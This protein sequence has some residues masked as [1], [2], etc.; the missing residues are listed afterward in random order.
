MNY[1]K[2]HPFTILEYLYKFSFLFIIP[3]LQ[4]LIIRPRKIIE[5]INIFGLNILFVLLIVAY[6]IKEYTAINYH[7]SKHSFYISQGIIVKKR[8]FI[9]YKN[10]HSII[11]SQNLI[12][13][14]FGATKL[15]LNTP[16]K[17]GKKSD[18]SL[19][20]SQKNLNK[21]LKSIYSKSS[22]KS[23]YNTSTFKIILMSAFWSNSAT[24]L[25]ILAP[26]INKLGSLI[27]EQAKEQ[28]YSTVDI[29]LQLIAFG[30]PPFAATLA[31]I[32]LTGWV[33]SFLVQFLRYKGFSVFKFDNNLLI[34][35]GLIN[36]YSRILNI[37]DINAISIK[38]S[39]FM[40]ILKL[41]SAYISAVGNNKEKGDKNMLIA[42]ATKKDVRSALYNIFLDSLFKSLNKN[43]ISKNYLLYSIS[44]VKKTIKSFIFIPTSILFMVLLLSTVL[45]LNSNYK[46][47]ILL[48]FIFVIPIIIWWITLRLLAYKHSGA[49]LYP[50]SLVI[51]GYKQLSLFSSHISLKKI[52]SIK[53]AQN[54]LQKKFERANLKVYIFSEQTEYFLVKH[55][56]LTDVENFVEKVNKLCI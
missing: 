26:F 33:I 11:V 20:L 31:N 18:V 37:K 32:L 23:V 5:I 4:Q 53:I 30:V 48:F 13:A 19:N 17:K 16:S 15:K 25:L 34:H 49:D 39:L 3:L 55:L 45:F 8:A 14:L 47:F 38:Q 35:R 12:P 29:S 44:P 43:K 40:K 27:G 51:K 2:T 56:N 41:E 46:Q 7:S 28:I 50:D 21:T 10:I 42:C 54:P 36:T 9:P 52:Q 22:G 6:S 24:G 1:N